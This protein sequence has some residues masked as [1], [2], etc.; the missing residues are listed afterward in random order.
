MV[1]N[2]NGKM[3]IFSILILNKLFFTFLLTT[4]GLTI[5]YPRQKPELIIDNAP[6]E[7]GGVFYETPSSTKTPRP[8]ATTTPSKAENFI[9]WKVTAYCPCKKCS[10][11]YG[12][13]TATGKTAKAG[14]TV[15]K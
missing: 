7:S 2:H 9:S 15:A 3:L 11:K 6:V 5:C 12:R 4:L 14:R 13:S 10:G 8:T 1:G